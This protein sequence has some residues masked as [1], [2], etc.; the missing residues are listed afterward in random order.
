M[1]PKLLCNGHKPYHGLFLPIPYE[2]RWDKSGAGSFFSPPHAQ[3]ELYPICSSQGCC[4]APGLLGLPGANGGCLEKHV[5][6]PWKH[7]A[8]LSLFS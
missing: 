8:Q 5:L 7:L 4:E 2:G 6:N 3:Q 1:Q